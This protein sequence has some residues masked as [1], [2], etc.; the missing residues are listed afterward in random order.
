MTDGCGPKVLLSSGMTASGHLLFF[1]CC[2]YGVFT[3]QWETLSS[4]GLMNGAPNWDNT[5]E[6]G[7]FFLSKANLSQNVV[8]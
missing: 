5:T 1:S 3:C 8:L 4:T 2:P 7:F 6:Y